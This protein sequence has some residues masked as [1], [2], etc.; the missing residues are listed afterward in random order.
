MGKCFG[1]RG[2]SPPPLFLFARKSYNGSHLTGRGWKAERGRLAAVDV[3]EVVLAGQ[4]THGEKLARLLHYF[5]VFCQRSYG[6]PQV[7][8]RLGDAEVEWV[9]G[10]GGEDALG[11]HEAGGH[12]DCG[13]AMWA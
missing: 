10:V 13:Y 6:S 8:G 5:Y 12:G 9:G 1:E 7:L 11:S 3:C 2:V 4:I